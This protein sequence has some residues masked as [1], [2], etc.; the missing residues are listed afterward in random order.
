LECG[1]ESAARLGLPHTPDCAPLPNFEELALPLFESVYHSA[2]WLAGSKPDAEDLVQDTY[3]KAFR[4]FSTFEPGSNFRAW[5]YR[6]LKNTFLNSRMSAHFR[7]R[8]NQLSA[9][10]VLEA[11]PSSDADPIDV[12]MNRDRQHAV[13]TAMSQLSPGLREVFEL[14]DLKGASYRETARELSIPI[15]TVMSRLARARKTLRDLIRSEHN[16]VI[17]T[18]SQRPAR[19]Q[20]PLLDAR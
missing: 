6:I 11:L 3:L 8:S 14:C 4:G 9:E 1:A 18:R 7:R 16:P 20:E 17:R 15:G 19:I 2:H 5:I 12:L 13:Q 10:E